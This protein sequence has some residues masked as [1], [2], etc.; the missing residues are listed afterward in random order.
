[1]RRTKCVWGG[2]TAVFVGLLL[3]GWV[4]NVSAQAGI[5]SQ[6]V[7]TDDP[8]A[9]WRLGESSTS[10]TAV[11]SATG[12][13]SAGIAAN[14]TYTSGVGV[15]TAGLI[16]GD[17]D[18]AI[19]I[20][21]N[22]S[23]RMFTNGFEKLGSGTGY[24][25]EYWTKL[26]TS[27]TGFMNMVGD[28][29]A[30][31]D[32]YLMSYL[33]GGGA[34]RAHTYTTNGINSID[35]TPTL[36]TN[37]IYHV[38]STWDKTTGQ[39]RIYING[40]QVATTVAA[41]SNP[42]SG[43]AV[44]TN[45]P[46]FIGKDNDASHLA[47]VVIDEP[48]IYNR[49]LSPSAILTHYVAGRLGVV[50][51]SNLTMPVSYWN[52]DEAASGTGTAYDL[53]DGND[54]SFVNNATRTAGLIGP[55]AAL[56]DYSGGQQPGV[57]VGSGVGQQNTFS[58]TTGITVEAL[59][60]PSQNLGTNRY[61]EIFRKE[62]GSNRILFSFQE[63]GTILSFGLNTGGYQELDMPLDGLSGRPTLAYFKDGKPHHVAATYDSATGEKAI[64]VD[65]VKRYSTLLPAGTLI[66][67]GGSAA[68]YIGNVS[69]LNEPFTGVID[70]V[71]IYNKA[72]PAWELWHHY[73]N[74]RLGQYYFAVPEP[75]SWALALAGG[76]LL[77]GWGWRRRLGASQAKTTP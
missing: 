23:D 18:K 61:E 24:T 57:N 76:V 69:W 37:K 15:N 41:G 68:A 75:S 2:A 56:F 31:G 5:Y 10:Q 1:M 66:T 73:Q 40:Q 39:M 16:F 46:I 67:S 9:Y 36:T 28:R 62:D 49:P 51:A 38:V 6:V 42:T 29:E 35:S 59:I 43:T 33:K 34:V 14:G 77:A 7:Q 32:F 17:P 50:T 63:Y 25:V 20:N 12:P 47:T 3:N 4:W 13:S 22:S 70:E 72:L 65:G 52:F 74:V 71:A 55:G 64:W 60:Q 27:P 21:N 19:T 58:F 44:N 26:G 30:S 11:N 48:A 8:V 54:G 45:N 53:F